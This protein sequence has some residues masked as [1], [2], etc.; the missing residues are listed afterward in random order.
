M[1][2]APECT[3]T[4]FRACLALRVG[5]EFDV[6]RTKDGVLVCLHDT[7]LDRTTNGRGNL[8]DLTYDQLKKLDA[9]SHFSAAFRGE[10]VPR[11]DE[12]FSLIA[13]E[14][15]GDMLFTV[16]LKETGDG[17]EEKIV[18]LAESRGVLAQLLFIG[19]TIES[20]EVR[21]RLKDAS[22]L[23]RTACLCNNA[24][25][26]KTAIA[27]ANTD[28]LYVRHLPSPAD[29][30]RIHS[31]NKRLFMSGPLVA[32]H[33]AANWSKAAELHI[34]AMLTDFPLDLANQLRGRTV[35]SALRGV[36]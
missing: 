13:D 9:G 21:E 5:F 20:A 22:D 17:L 25:E 2:S 23:A 12:I 29:I 16:D 31:A 26:I 14:S 10:Q 3:L 15:R 32:G 33:E 27:D 1:H 34:D 6:R 19:K 30:N 8:A 4:A 24:D 11:I 35:G 28:W 18:R 36:P 7:T